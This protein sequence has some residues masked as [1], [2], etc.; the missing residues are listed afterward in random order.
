MIVLAIFALVYFFGGDRLFPARTP[1][2]P[3]GEHIFIHYIDVGQGNAVLIQSAD[4]AVLIDAGEARYG[5][6]VVT[7]L[8]EAG[9]TRLDYVVATHPHS[10]HI[11]GLI[12]VIN[13]KEVGYVIWPD[14]TNNTVAFENLMAAIINH[15]INTRTVTAGDRINAGIIDLAVLA[16]AGQH[17]PRANNDLNNTSV[18]LR[19][20]YGD[21]AFLFTGD[22]ER[23][24]EEAMIAAGFN[25]RSTVLLAGHHGSNTSTT[26]AFLDA[27][28][29]LVVVISSGAGNTHGHPHP[30]VIAR[31]EEHGVQRILRTDELG[32]ILLTTDG[33][34]VRL[35]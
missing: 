27:V 4:H 14:A 21:T 3:T 30:A 29:P 35:W 17:V 9:V 20:V 11:G 34:E 32:D 28:D 16:P 8:R 19:L 1:F 5:T 31:L 6:R 33:M 10:D 24:A 2:L 18:A 12:A 26:Q 7:Y 22:A 13:Q 23:A 15:D 25:L